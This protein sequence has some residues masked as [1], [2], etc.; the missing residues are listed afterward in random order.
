MKLGSNTFLNA[1][2][3]NWK[4]Q[5]EGVG[6]IQQHIVLNQMIL[7]HVLEINTPNQL[8]HAW[9]IYSLPT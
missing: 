1:I 7:L 5:M 3:I 4:F 6:L 9:C 8:L 2:I